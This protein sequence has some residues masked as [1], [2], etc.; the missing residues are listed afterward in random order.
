MIAKSPLAWDDFRM[1]KAIADR[2]ALTQAAAHLGINHST[3]FRRLQQIEAALGTTLFERHR[4]GYVATP[5]GEAMV[6]AAAR[7]EADVAGF[8]REV[9]DRADTPAGTLRITAAAGFVAELLVPL[10]GRFLARYPAVRADLVV[11]EEALNLSRRDADVAL[12]AGIDPPPT[13]VGRRL[14]GIAWAIYGRADDG[15]ALSGRWVGL[16]D[17]VAGGRFARF[18]RA[19][20]GAD[21]IVLQLNTV[22]GLREAIAAGIGVGPLP[23]YAG[24]AD[25][26]LR[27]LGEPEPDLAADLWLLTHPGLRHAPRV[28]AFM[29]FAAEAIA[30][31]RPAFEGAPPTGGREKCNLA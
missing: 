8:G 22:M 5:A 4:T 14:S 19:R 11:A 13:L 24:D 6:A 27:R 3:A 7:M 16:S 1:V 23:C 9:A 15:A 30:A 20:A 2:G 17:S 31:M 21:R 25:P 10:V 28:R 26:T 12:R 18:V 29:D